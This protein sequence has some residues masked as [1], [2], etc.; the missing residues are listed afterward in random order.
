MYE[1]RS[2]PA[3]VEIGEI[4]VER[5]GC[6][7]DALFAFDV[8]RIEVV[9]EPVAD[10]AVRLRAAGHEREMP[11]VRLVVVALRAVDM[12]PMTARPGAIARAASRCHNVEAA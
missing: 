12:M 5:Q 7:E 9:D 8:E 1:G 4:V 2:T 11:A 10:G 3:A 6:C